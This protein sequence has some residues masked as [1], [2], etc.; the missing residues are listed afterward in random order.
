ME[1][2]GWENRERARLPPHRRNLGQDLRDEALSA[3][4]AFHHKQWSGIRPKANG[5]SIDGVEHKAF[6]PYLQ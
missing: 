6:P 4:I 2:R 3:G 1:P 5:C